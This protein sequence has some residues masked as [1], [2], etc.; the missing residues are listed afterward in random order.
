MHINKVVF[1]G[2]IV[3]VAFIYFIFHTAKKN[4]KI[5][6]NKSF[7]VYFFSCFGIVSPSE[8]IRE[9]KKSMMVGKYSRGGIYPN[10]PMSPEQDRA[11][12]IYY[13]EA[14]TMYA[15]EEVEYP[16]RSHTFW[17]KMFICPGA[18]VNAPRDEATRVAEIA[19]YDARRK[20]SKK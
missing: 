11:M 19:A 13:G 9:H 3:M 6:Q 20:A 8:Y 7:F 14:Y 15:D 18:E 10:E 4:R 16:D 5:P 1:I 2:F 12:R 17:G